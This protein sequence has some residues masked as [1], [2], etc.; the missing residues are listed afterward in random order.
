MKYKLYNLTFRNF[1]ELTSFLHEFSSSPVRLL[2]CFMISFFNS[3]LDGNPIEP[4]S[5]SRIE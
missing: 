5:P 3:S 1:K 4:V 2:I